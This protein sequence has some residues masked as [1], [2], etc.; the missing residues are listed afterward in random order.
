MSDE[1]A[2]ATPVTSTVDEA[3]TTTEVPE[4]P[5]S[6]GDTSDATPEGADP[7]SDPDDDTGLSRRDIRYREQ[8]RAAE[9][10]RDTLRTTVETM[11]RREVERLAAEHVVK[12]AALWTAGTELANL[13]GED[14]TVDPEKV[15]TAAA[16][17]RQQ[18]G[19][20]HPQAK[21]LRSPVVAKEGTSYRGHGDGGNSSWADAFKLE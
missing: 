10:E 2:E 12:P 16:D 4:E 15:A 3:T 1:T 19:L 5:Q 13:L 7:E 21:R 20:E 8:L 18:L 17:A 14:G 11:Q 6:K 9:A